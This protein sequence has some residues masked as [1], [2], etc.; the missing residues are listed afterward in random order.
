VATK[1]VML[2]ALFPPA[3]AIAV[4]GGAFKRGEDAILPEGKRF[5]VYVERDTNV[6]IAAED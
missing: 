5:V 3:A 2:G 4:V 1:T 6:T